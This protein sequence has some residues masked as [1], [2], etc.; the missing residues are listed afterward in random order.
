MQRERDSN[1]R[2]QSTTELQYIALN[3]QPPQ[4]K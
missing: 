3:T 2:V 4:I 1:S